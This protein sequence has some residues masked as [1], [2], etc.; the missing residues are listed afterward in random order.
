[1]SFIRNNARKLM[2][3]IIALVLC[4]GFAG[5]NKDSEKDDVL[6]TAVAGIVMD[7][8]IGTLASNLVLPE[9]AAGKYPITWTI[10]ANDYA[11]IGTNREGLQMI[12]ISRPES[13]KGYQKFNITATIEQDGTKATRTWE[14]YVKPLAEGI[15]V[16]TAE[17]VKAAEVNTSLSITGTVLI[18]CKS[19]G[20]W[21]ADETG[22]AYVYG[23]VGDVQ[24]GDKVTVTGTKT[25]YYSLTE[26]EN[27]GISIDEFGTGTYPYEEKAVAMTADEIIALDSKDQSK[28]GMLAKVQGTVIKDVNSGGSYTYGIKDYKTGNSITIYDSCTNPE[29]LETLKGKLDQYIE[30]VVLVYDFHSNGYWRTVAINSTIRDAEIPTISDEEKVATTKAQLQ[31]QFENASIFAD[32]ALPTANDFEGLTI[33]W[34]SDKP[35]VFSNEGKI[36]TSEAVENAVKLTAVIK[37]GALEETV[38]FTIN[39]FMLSKS[40]IAQANAMCDLG[41]SDIWV[42]GKIVAMDVDGYFYLADET[43]VIYVRTKLAEGIA[44]GDTVKIVGKTANY[45]NKGKQWTRQLTAN[46]MTK[47]ETEVTP[48]TAMPLT[49]ENLAKPE[50][51]GGVLTEAGNAAIKNHSGYGKIVEIFG[52]VQTRGS[53]GNVYICEDATAESF[54]VV[55]YYKS[56][57]QDGMKA[58]AGKLVKLTCVLYDASGS[59]G[60]RIGSYIS[61]EEVAEGTIK[62]A[63]TADA[64]TVKEIIALANKEALVVDGTV[65]YVSTSNGFILEDAAGDRI[66]VYGKNP[67]CKLGDKV[68]V[69]GVKGEYNQAPQIA[70]P[71]VT[72]K[73]AGTYNYAYEEITI[74]A[75]NALSYEDKTVFGKIYKVKGTLTEGNYINLQNGDVLNNLYS[76]P[77]NKEILAKFGPVEVELLV[78]VYQYN[79]KVSTYNLF[80]IASTA[81]AVAK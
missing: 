22:A 76:D 35:E 32:T 19:A 65:I 62:V 33:T 59:D 51:E 6:E 43:G 74:D 26:I 52:Y 20:F 54:G 9:K 34:T 45:A 46:S 53:F 8:S 48:I 7:K 47:L 56:F 3:L 70:S 79:S 80:P 29:A 58:L 14:G 24:V 72:V 49:L 16:L 44:K 5:C 38:E 36:G 31:K 13:S 2:I 40:T 21:V 68:S 50:A 42:E 77:A 78:I 81:V 57:D 67:I 55:Y 39:V 71:V 30:L 28:Y 4:F 61:I 25:I 1:M 23:S 17:Q 64:K 11:E 63:P 41:A 73:S 27:P 12:K 18:V 66:F 69:S 10:E 37:A 75:L 60:W 15:Q